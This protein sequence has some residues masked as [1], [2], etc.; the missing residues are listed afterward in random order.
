MGP[1]LPSIPPFTLPTG[2]TGPSPTMRLQF[3]YMANSGVGDNT[4]EIY[5]ISNPTVPVRVGE[6]NGGNLDGPAGLIITSTIL[7]VT[8]FNEDTVE[9]YDIKNPILPVRVG[10][11]NGGNLNGPAS[12]KYIRNE[13]ICE[14]SYI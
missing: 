7:Y 13:Y 9:I 6:F 4:V 1:T 3:L 10:E 11:F 12:L 14:F 2:P 8:N 5:N